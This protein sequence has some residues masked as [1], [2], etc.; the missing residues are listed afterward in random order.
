M[1]IIT[2]SP[3][4]VKREEA[5]NP[6]RRGVFRLII[7]ESGRRRLKLAKVCKAEYYKGSPFIQED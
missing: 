2:F 3:L 7:D 6:W 4:K 1:C 5:N